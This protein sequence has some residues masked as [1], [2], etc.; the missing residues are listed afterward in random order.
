MP[1]PY[2][3]P[4]HE[5]FRQVFRRFLDTEARPYFS[6]WEHRRQ[7]PREFWRKMGSHG[8]LCPMV[9]E[10]YGGSGADFGYAVVITEE[11]ERIGSGLGG[12]G[13]HNDI[14]VPYIVQ[15]AR[16][17][18]KEHWLPRCASGDII[19]A[20]AMTE[21]EA[22]SDLASIRTV[23]EHDGDDYVVTGQKTFITNGGQADLVVVAVKTDPAAKP[24]HRGIS[25]LCIEADTPGFRRGRVFHKI[26]QHSQDTA[27][28]FFDHCRVPRD[29]LLGEEGEGFRYLTE[30]L[31]QERLMVAIAAQAGMERALELTREYVTRRIQFGQPLSR[32]QT[33]RFTMAEL[34]TRVQVSRAFVDSVIVRH[35]EGSATV[36]DASMAKWWATDTARAVIGACLQLH[37]GNGYMEDYEIARRYRDIAVMPIYAGTNEIMKTIIA[38]EVLD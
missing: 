13:L 17:E 3:T 6:E 8:F 16:P 32:L 19:T 15:Y 23:A 35:M 9:E 34:Y 5:E 37:G 14:V 24:P 29:H 2:L 11:L 10:T 33:I 18:M 12:I 20:I 4:E 27:E 30:N 7:V 28:L 26:G 25:L 1:H 38:K 31:R 36:S 22:G 21:P